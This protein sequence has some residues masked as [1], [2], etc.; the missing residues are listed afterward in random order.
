MRKH[1]F[2]LLTLVFCAPVWA[3][4]M[5]DNMYFRAMKDEMDR[6]LKELRVKGSPDPYYAAFKLS[7]KRDIRARASFGETYPRES[8]TDTLE[9]LVMLPAGTPRSDSLGFD[10]DRFYYRPGHDYNIAQSYEG[11]RQALWMLA[12]RGYMEASDA[13][14]NKQ[15]Y[16]RQKNLTDKLPD[17]IRAPQAS[18]VE[19]IPAFAPPPTEALENLARALSAKGRGVAYLEDFSAE[20]RAGRDEIYYLNSDGGLYQLARPY[21]RVVLSARLRNRDGYKEEL[22]REIRLADAALLDEKEL[23]KQTDEF[24]AE[25]DKVHNAKKAEPYL[26][27]VLLKPQAASGFL[28]ALFIRNMRNIKPLLSAL[29]DND[30]TA[31]LFRDKTGMRVMSNVIDVYDKPLLRSYK[32][33]PLDGFMPVDDEGVAPK[34]LTLVSAGRLRELPLSR[35]P[36]KEGNQSNG[37]ARMGWGTNPREALTNVFVEAKQPL[38]DAEMEAKLLSRCRELELEYCYVLT[39]FPA[40]GNSPQTGTVNTAERIYTKDGR[41]EPVF[42][43]KIAGLTTRSLRDILAAG[44]DEEVTYAHDSYDRSFS[45]VTPSLLVDEIEIL[46][47]EKKAD[48]KPFI[49]KP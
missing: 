42:G 17:F 31:G 28:S 4:H 26:G 43:V 11:I 30:P 10:S 38:S 29:Q 47:D 39:R 1:F 27:P 20:V 14:E 12:D 46:P 34:E 49:A 36:A 41:R 19:D 45:V 2:F 21:G 25:L 8:Q 40:V 16:K 9:A 3:A 32:G 13:Y 37:H 22:R 23:E 18:F 33:K 44:A 7:L 15:A 35:R 5:P 24:L 48:R 6:S